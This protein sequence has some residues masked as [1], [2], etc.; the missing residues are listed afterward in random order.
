MNFE[1]LVTTLEERLQSLLKSKEVIVLESG[2]YREVEMVSL[3]HV[4]VFHVIGM[5]CHPN[6]AK[7][8][9]EFL[10]ITCAISGMHDLRANLKVQW[11]DTFF[12]STGAGYVKEE[13]RPVGV[14]ITCDADIAVFEKK[15]REALWIF[16]NVARRGKPRHWFIRRLSGAP[17]DIKGLK[18][19]VSPRS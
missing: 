16:E 17:R 9:M 2:L 10:S 11:S 7:G 6:W 19:D 5:R 4:D 15:F 1:L 12:P 13:R 3:R 14:K 18:E 8:N